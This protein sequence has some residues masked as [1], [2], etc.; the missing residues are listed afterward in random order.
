MT[1]FE[2]LSVAVSIVLSLS[3]AQILANIRAAL[4]RDRWYWVHALWIFLALFTH[5]LIWWEFWGYRDVVEW[6]LEKFVVVLANPGLLFVASH[7]LSTPASAS[8]ASWEDHYYSARFSFFAPFGAILLIAILRDG[9][10]LDRSFETTQHIPE[11]ILLLIC[12]VAARSQSRRTHAVLALVSLV[13]IVAGMASIWNEPG[14]A[15]NPRTAGQRAVEADVLEPGRSR[16]CWG[17]EANRGIDVA[18]PRRAVASSPDRATVS[19]RL[20]DRL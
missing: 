6:T 19:M 1:L 2:Y 4:D 18:A 9:F 3:A 20:G 17:T 5:I 7:A 14:G 12:A 16:P 8:N 11:F 15:S 10:I 13:I